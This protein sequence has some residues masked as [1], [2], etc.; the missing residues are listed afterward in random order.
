MN[1]WFGD[2]KFNMEGGSIVSDFIEE[3]KADDFKLEDLIER[4]R[5][6]K[7]LFYVD[8]VRK[9]CG[10]WVKIPVMLVSGKKKGKLLLT[11]ACCHGDEYEGAEGIAE[12]YNSLE[13][14]E[15][16]GA[17]VGIPALNLAAFGGMSRFSSDDFVPVDMNRAFPGN[18]TGTV[19]NYIAYYYTENF[20][21][22]ADGLVTIHGGGNTLYLKPV[23]CHPKK[24]DDVSKISQQMAEA[25]NFDVIWEDKDI[26]GSYGLMDQNAYLLGVPVV[27]A[28]IGGQ[29]VRHFERQESSRRICEGM[30]NIMRLFG[31]VSG[32]VVK[33]EPE[34]VVNLSYIY[35]NN[36]GIHKPLLKDGERFSKGQ[37]LSE[38]TDVFGNVTEKITAGFDGV[39]VGYL[40]YSTVNPKS[41]VYLVGEEVK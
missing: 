6:E 34:Y 11:D 32:E 38:I 16:S 24:D 9:T 37:V 30:I 28:E 1:I 14:G 35:S 5:G 27:T 40:A 41:W 2:Y 13:P 17:F 15:M 36:G 29:S 10:D 19:T 7:C 20:I 23:A 31:I 33:K 18:K 8:L 3:I 25:M 21:K 39:V 26:N 22:K 12:I 4:H